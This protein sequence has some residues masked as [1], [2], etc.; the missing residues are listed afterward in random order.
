MKE[1]NMS[2]LE[3]LESMSDREI[4]DWLRKVDFTTLALALL[5]VSDSIRNLVHRNL[6]NR[7]SDILKQTI[8]TYGSMDAKQLL[9]Q[10]SA[11]KLQTLI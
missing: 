10:T 7:A 4:Q 6:S 11:D 2:I 3:R 8:Q 9:I 1:N 5:G